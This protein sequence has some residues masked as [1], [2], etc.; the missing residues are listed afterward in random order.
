MNRRSC[1]CDVINFGHFV[2]KYL[3]NLEGGS[4]DTVNIDVLTSVFKGQIV[5][6]WR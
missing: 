1:V 5:S 2:T 4:S 3:C 6:L